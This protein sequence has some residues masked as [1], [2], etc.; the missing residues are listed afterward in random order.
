MLAGRESGMGRSAMWSAARTA[1]PRAALA[2]SVAL[3][4][5]LAGG[6]AAD[7]SGVGDGSGAGAG[8][9]PGTSAPLSVRSVEIFVDERPDFSFLSEPEL[10]M[11]C[12]P[13]GGP[14]GEI[15]EWLRRETSKDLSPLS[16]LSSPAAIDR[17]KQFGAV[18]T[19]IGGIQETD[20]LY[21]TDISLG[22]WPVYPPFFPP[23]LKSE[24]VTNDL[25]EEVVYEI[26]CE[27]WEVRLTPRL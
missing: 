8:A 5:A 6:A 21:A 13:R 2:L 16:L 10:Y 1:T 24:V 15:S 9:R 17:L 22:N 26:K 19:A 14:S 27:M 12:L 25:G 20:V 11:F 3:A 7:E 23:W 4:L 18:A